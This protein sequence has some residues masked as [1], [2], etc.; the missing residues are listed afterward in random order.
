MKIAI[1]GTGYVGLSTGVCLSEIGHLV[2]C[3]DTN[4]QKIARL[5]KGISPIYEPGID[6]LLLKNIASGNLHFTVSHKE[7][8]AEADII[9]VAVG[10]PQKDDGSADLTFIE[11]AVYDIAANLD[12]EAVVV[13][14]S[15]VPVGTNDRVRELLQKALPDHFTTHVVSNPEFLRQ[16]SAVRDTMEADRIV[17]GAENE[18]A[19]Q[20]VKEMYSPLHVPVI[21]TTNRSAEMI[22]YA[23]NSFLATKISFINEIAN[24]CEATGAD[25]LDVVQGMSLD[26]R[27]GNQFFNPGIGYG[28]SCFPKDVKALL[29][30]AKQYNREFAILKETV[31]INESQRT[32]LVNKAISRFE[33]VTGKKFAMLGLAFKPET[34]DMREAPSI[35]IARMLTELGAEV[36]AYDPVAMENG[37]RVIGKT[38]KYA[39]SLYEAA[40]NADALLIVTEWDEFRKVDLKKLSE[41]MKQLIIFDGRNCLDQARIKSFPSI[42]YYPIG[43][44][45]IIKNRI[46]I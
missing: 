32:L 25:V 10:T 29:H 31:A 35:P 21:L 11:L 19:A 40:Q 1:I 22:K 24:L 15:T 39:N 20:K 14:K 2:T 30:T 18:A 33:N 44:P 41:M 8:L 12:H 38:I 16:G 4:E 6:E 45:A 36:V 27:I 7:G 26:Q 43:R 46:K 42:E 28:G 17:I 37:K 5:L 34:D 13:I 23:S 3:I 9:I